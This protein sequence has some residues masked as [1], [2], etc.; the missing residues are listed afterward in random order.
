MNAIFVNVRQS[1]EDCRSHHAWVIKASKKDDFQILVEVTKNEIVEIRAILNG[2]VV[3]ASQYDDF[4]GERVNFRSMP[5]SCIYS[6]EMVKVI[7]KKVLA[8]FITPTKYVVKQEYN[9]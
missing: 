5:L 9:I 7:R 4:E 3:E 6:N 8:K 1:I 2:H